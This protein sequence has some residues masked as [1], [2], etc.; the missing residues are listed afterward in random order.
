MCDSCLKNSEEIQLAN[1][2]FM[3]RVG[4]GT[5]GRMNQGPIN[6][7]LEEGVRLFDTA[8]AREWY[9]EDA[10]AAAINAKNNR[11]KYFIVS[12][13]HP[14][15]H[16]YASCLAAIQDSAQK[17]HGMYIDAFLLHYPSCWD[18][19]C[20]SGW[21]SRVQG[22]W[23]DSWRAMETAY[24]QGLVRAIGISNFNLDELRH[25]QD[26]AAIKPHLVQNW[27]DP[28]HQDSAVRAFCQQNSI[29]YMSYS[30]LGTQWRQSANP[31]ATSPVLAQI[32]ATF[33]HA[34]VQTV[35]LAWALQRGVVVL[36]R[37]FKS[38][39]IK[40]NA[41]LFSSNQLTPCLS[42]AQ[43]SAIDDL[44]AT[45]DQSASS[46]AITATFTSDFPAHVYWLDDNNAQH[47]VASIIGFNDKSG[48][49]EAQTTKTSITTYKGHR[50][51][52]IPQH[53]GGNATTLFTV[54][55]KPGSRQNFHLRADHHDD[56]EEEL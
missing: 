30:T 55:A 5:A 22:T 56:A 50:F 8:R 32:A 3:P 51:L 9:N 40:A 53:G 14:R 25:L 34:T 29:V 46:N 1:S 39:H 47:F 37:S 33:D 54:N 10:L 18:G 7:A 6:I 41:H 27:M 49:G 2:I 35:T 26:F 42:S 16:G 36:P 19:L 4:L 28:F 21:E 13:L 15:D 12:K 23:R 48:G 31:V 43:L 52:V 24:R 38:H 17:F 44:D 11:S 20:G 45:Y